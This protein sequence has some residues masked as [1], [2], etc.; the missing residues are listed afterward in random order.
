LNL[1]NK[2]RQLFSNFKALHPID[3]A[4]VSTLYALSEKSLITATVF[5]II[6]V[7]ALYPE[8][9]Y[10]IVLWGALVITIISVRLYDA[11]LFKT[12]PQKYPL[13][14]WYKRFIVLSMLTGVIVS[15]LGF[16]F[17]H[18]SND[19]YQLFILASLMGLTA[20]ASISLSSDI[21]IAIIYISIIIIPLIVSLALVQTPLNIVIPILL[22]LFLIMQITM[23]V[24]SHMQEQEI[25]ELQGERNLLDISLE[26]QLEKNQLLLNENKLFIADMVH[27][28]KT[29][30]S[31][32]ITNEIK[33]GFLHLYR[34]YGEEI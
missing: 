22:I 27:Q 31:V 4:L 14:I 1:L 29:P 10:S 26:E 16:W 28:I 5:T 21:R 2:F 15:T 20:G 24:K 7:T 25:I 3:N 8:L 12:A 6:I 11:R 34:I 13:E 30:L 18:Y 33:F 32:I 17:I 9:S 23:I 19:Y